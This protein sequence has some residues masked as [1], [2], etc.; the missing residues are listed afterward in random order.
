M[1]YTLTGVRGNDDD[2]DAKLWGCCSLTFK[3]D[4]RFETKT[5]PRSIDVLIQS[6]LG[7]GASKGKRQNG[8]HWLDLDPQSLCGIDAKTN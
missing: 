4:A 2:D 5:T 6:S 7:R 8:K 3:V 1:A